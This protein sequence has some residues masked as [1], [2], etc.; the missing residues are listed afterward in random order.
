VIVVPEAEVERGVAP[1]DA[2]DDWLGLLHA[3]LPVEAAGR[4]AVL[5]G[6]GA[7]VTFTGTVRD[8]SGDRSGVTELLYEAYE[9]QVVRRLAVVASAARTRWPQI[10]RLVLLHRV[11]LLQVTD[12]AVVVVVSTPHRAEAFDAARF[13]IDALKATAP[14]WKRE[15]WDGGE[16]WVACHHVA[17]VDGTEPA[18]APADPGPRP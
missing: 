10:G 5:G 11:G 13:C 18:P 3:E 4:W 9:E 1:P 8:H 6:C 12:A 16:E 2:G 15:S 14:I 7:V 17:P